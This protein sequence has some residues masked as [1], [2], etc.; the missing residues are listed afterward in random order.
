MTGNLN[1]F[2]SACKGFDPKT[3]SA[4]GFY[5]HINVKD[6]HMDLHVFTGI[7]YVGCDE[8][9][10][11]RLDYYLKC[12][13]DFDDSGQQGKKIPLFAIAG[14]GNA[15]IKE[16]DGHITYENM[17]VQGR[18]MTIPCSGEY[19]IQVYQMDGDMKIE[20]D[21]NIRYKK[22]QEKGSIPSSA[23]RFTITKE[24]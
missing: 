21:P 18:E 24:G 7:N 3:S 10:E 8:D 9:H 14:S 5:N 4:I 11:F 22:Y 12:I 17:F 15:K 19:E 20:E 1:I 2:V 13:K 16:N 23:F 6:N